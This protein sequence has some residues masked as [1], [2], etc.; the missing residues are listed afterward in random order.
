MKNLTLDPFDIKLLHKNN[1]TGIKIAKSLTSISLI[2][3]FICGMDWYLYFIIKQTS[4]LEIVLLIFLLGFLLFYTLNLIVFGIHKLIYKIKRR[5]GVSQAPQTEGIFN[6]YINNFNLIF[7]LSTTFLFVLISTFL[8]V[9]LDTAGEELEYLIGVSLIFSLFP[10]IV[11]FSYKPNNRTIS[12]ELK[13]ILTDPI[14]IASQKLNLEYSI[15]KT[16]SVLSNKE[17]N[18]VAIKHNHDGNYCVE[19]YNVIGIYRPTSD[20][21]GTPTSE[22]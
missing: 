13:E 4:V 2:A 16:S 14:A 9:V 12:Y 18:I 5:R 15:D 3:L 11:I 6:S 8:L 19:I 17:K 20:E 22:N 1:H 21:P 7:I 10:S